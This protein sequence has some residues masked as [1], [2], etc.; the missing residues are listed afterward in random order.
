MKDR[1][2]RVAR[3][4]VA[5]VLLAPGMVAGQQMPEGKPEEPFFHQFLIPGDPLDEKLLEQEKR[6]AANGSSAAL[7]NDFGNLLAERRFPKEARA[8]Y[9]KALELD[10]HFFLAA[11]NLGMMEETEGR[12]SAAISA[13]REAIDRRPGFPPAH[14]RLGRVYEK[15]GRRDDAIQAYAKA[16]R[17]NEAMRDP[18][19]NP[20][21]VDSQLIDQASLVNYPRELA[22]AAERHDAGYV[23]EAR[24][25][26]MPAD[27]PL[28]ADEVV[29][30]AGPQTI[31]PS[32]TAP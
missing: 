19:W 31:E 22:R 32:R 21:V 30:E 17:I 3:L 24:F 1:R 12:I 14:F 4:A 6:V 26:S 18:R 25:L 8:E 13:Y 23:D 11:Y 5:F 28:D 20:L 2:K 7:R 15:L 29:E 27:R 10:P 16:I 9:K